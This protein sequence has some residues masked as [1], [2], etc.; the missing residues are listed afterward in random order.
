MVR[1]TR[2]DRPAGP[3]KGA[4]QHALELLARRD[5]TCQAMHERLRADGYSLEDGTDAMSYLVEAGYLDDRRFAERFIAGDSGQHGPDWLRRE[6]AARGVP[7]GVVAEALT[8]A[9]AERGPDDD[10][11]TAAR[12]LHEQQPGLT[13]SKLAARLF[14]RGF[15][16]ESIREA[17]ARLGLSLDDPP[18]P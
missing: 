10:V 1:S 5:W 8:A 12:A 4:R 15:S 9:R 2:T 6:L 13:P 17:L 7:A 18:E 11:E 14:R 3:T 16:E